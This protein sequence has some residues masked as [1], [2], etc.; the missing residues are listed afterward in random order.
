M[1]PIVRVSTLH[2]LDHRQPFF[3]GQ[4]RQTHDVNGNLISRTDFNGRTTTFTYDGSNQLIRKTFPGR[5]QSKQ[6]AELRL[7]QGI[8]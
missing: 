3:L 1:V 5:E 4:D 8:G 2:T 7:S 6:T